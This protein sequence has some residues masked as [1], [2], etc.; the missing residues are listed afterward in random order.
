MNPK[1]INVDSL[2]DYVYLQD[3]VI[4]YESVIKKVVP[5]QSLELLLSCCEDNIYDEDG[6]QINYH[7]AWD[8]F[9]Q[10]LIRRHK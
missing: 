5:P 9:V 8:D 4:K 1:C 7:D 3:G 6:E 2:S 10:E